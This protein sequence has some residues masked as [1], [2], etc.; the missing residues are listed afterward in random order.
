[1]ESFSVKMETQTVM[2]GLLIP[3]RWGEKESGERSRYRTKSG[4][5]KRMRAEGEESEMKAAGTPASLK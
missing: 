5:D 4:R 2:R 3:G 1:M